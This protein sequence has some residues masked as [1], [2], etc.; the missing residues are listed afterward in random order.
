[1]ADKTETYQKEINL[2][3]DQGEAAMIFAA[4]VDRIL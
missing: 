3:M 1:V 2:G 4:K